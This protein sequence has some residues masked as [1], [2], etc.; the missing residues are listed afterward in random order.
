MKG[1]TLSCPN[2]GKQLIGTIERYSPNLGGVVKENTC[3]FCSGKFY[4][5][6]IGKGQYIVDIES[7]EEYEDE[8]DA[9]G[10]KKW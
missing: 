10:G 5:E 9:G 7:Y 2:C 4:V 6:Y 8:D 3:Q 1:E